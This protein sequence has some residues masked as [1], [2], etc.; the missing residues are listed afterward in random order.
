VE[1]PSSTTSDLGSFVT[2]PG[3]T[4]PP[5]AHVLDGRFGDEVRLLGYD[6]SGD[7]VGRGGQLEVT[8]H[9]QA[10]A[11][12]EGVRFFSHL[13]GP[14]GFMNL[15][16]A[17]VQGSHPLARWRAGETIRDR[18][19]IAVPTTFSPGSYTLLIGFWRPAGN[20]RLTVKPPERD[21]GQRRFSVLTFT[22]E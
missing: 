17:P 2:P 10:L 18:F 21:D 7:R 12:L 3:G 11:P 14:S 22:V 1:L 20:Q 4:A 9:F 5:P 16:H 13:V 19:S 15:D 6:V 8:L